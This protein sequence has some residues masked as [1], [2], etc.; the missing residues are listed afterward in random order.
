M[1]SQ[2]REQVHTWKIKAEQRKVK[3]ANLAK[4]L[5]VTKQAL[6]AA[7]AQ[8][9]SAYEAAEA[10]EEDGRMWKLVAEQAQEEETRLRMEL[11]WAGQRVADCEL[12]SEMAGR[13]RE[14]GAEERG[15]AGGSGSGQDVSRAHER[16]GGV[17]A[18]GGG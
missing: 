9:A 12:A 18:G 5:T 10:N 2:L 3:T 14:G 8:H 16:V 15:E 7:T 13:A 1:W 6:D 11:E 17:G 4:E